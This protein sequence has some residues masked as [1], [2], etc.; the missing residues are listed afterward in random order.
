MAFERRRNGIR[1]L[2]CTKRRALQKK[3]KSKKHRTPA[4][5]ENTVKAETCTSEWNETITDLY[6]LQQLALVKNK[7]RQHWHREENL[8]DMNLWG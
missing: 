8:K 6:I 7:I 1:L 3:K 2:Y 5:Q 4:T